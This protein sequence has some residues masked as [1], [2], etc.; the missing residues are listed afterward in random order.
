MFER[1]NTNVFKPWKPVLAIL[2]LDNYLHVFD[3]PSS[4]SKAA[5]AATATAAAAAAQ[6]AFESLVAKPET[7][8]RASG[9]LPLASPTTNLFPTDNEGGKQPL[10]IVSP[11]M[12][13]N[14]DLCEAH[15]KDARSVKDMS[16]DIVEVGVRGGGS[17]SLQRVFK[18]LTNK[19]VVTLK[20][21]DKA[22]MTEWC[23]VFHTLKRMKCVDAAV[24][25]R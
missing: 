22:E 21:R 13:F 7:V 3:L 23:N 15:F 6:E 11:S 1:K 2:T 17:M 10:G 16:F 25:A 9:A 8:G 4:R 20:G 18:D 14:L 24:G 5:T 19:Q 12:T